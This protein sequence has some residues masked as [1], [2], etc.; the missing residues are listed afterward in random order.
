MTTPVLNEGFRAGE[1]MVSEGEGFR[2]RDQGILLTGQVVAAGTVLGR[3][4]LGGATA[5]ATAGDTGNG[6]VGAVTVGAAAQV[7]TYTLAV[8]VAAAGA[9]TFEVVDPRG[10]VCGVG[11]VG[12]PFAGG[13]LGFTVTHGATDFVV[14]DSFAITVAATSGKYVAL[15]PAALDGSEKACAIAYANVDASAGD[16][17]LTITARAAEVNGNCLT[18]PAGITAPQL[19]AATAQLAALGIIVR[20]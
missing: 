15:N 6:T 11:T 5:V 1:Y 2:S 14:G 20:A 12:E 9:G 10:E 19:A 16:H 3:S 4:I 17:R 13:G 18:W 8:T 7:G